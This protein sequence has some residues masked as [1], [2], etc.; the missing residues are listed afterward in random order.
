MYIR[1]W[2]ILVLCLSVQAFGQDCMPALTESD[3]AQT[4]PTDLG[5]FGQNDGNSSF[6]QPEQRVDG[7]RMIAL[8]RAIQADSTERIV[9]NAAP[10][11]SLPFRDSSAMSVWD[12]I[13]RLPDDWLRFSRCAFR[14]ENAP[15]IGGIVISTIAS[16]VYDKELYDPVREQYKASSTTAFAMDRGVDIGDGKFQFG[17][18]AGFALYGWAKSDKHALRT[19]LQV[20]EVILAAGGVVQL[21]KHLTGRE[22]PFTA[23]KPT[24]RW[25]LFPNQIEY[26]KHVPHYDAFPSGHVCT[27][28]A[29]LTVVAENYPEAKWLR[30]VG[31]PA[32]AWLGYSMV[33]QGIHWVSDYPLS[34]ALGYTFGMLIAH[35]ESFSD[36]LHETLG[37]KSTTTDIFPFVS[38]NGAYGLQVHVSW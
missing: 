29:T 4:I 28:L 27:A 6:S 15:L 13:T 8:S 34:I 2:R 7:D 38:S 17:I 32:V 21:L 14:W 37:L 26:I 3:T 31:Y 18:A 9:Q 5:L 20:S 33:G 30:Y 16:V 10:L 12:P 23:T 11:D 25:V 24:G 35:P 1:L 36:S 19:A 22:S